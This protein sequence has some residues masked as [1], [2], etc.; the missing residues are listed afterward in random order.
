MRC[1]ILRAAGGLL[2][3][4][5]LLGL[6][7]CAY[8]RSDTLAHWPHGDPMR[9]NVEKE[10]ELGAPKIGVARREEILARLGEPDQ[11]SEDQREFVYRWRMV[12]SPSCGGGMKS[13]YLLRIL[14]D[15]KGIVSEIEYP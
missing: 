8:Y 2:L 10:L 6:P 5:H 1:R 7:G 12:T 13:T 15:E 9:Q 11:V 4:L 14:F 3:A